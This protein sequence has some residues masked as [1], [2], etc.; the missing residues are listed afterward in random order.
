MLDDPTAATPHFTPD[1]AGAYQVA[2]VVRDS[3]GLSSTKAVLNLNVAPCGTSN[4][5]WNGAPELTPALIEPGGATLTASL[6]GGAWTGAFVGTI[7][8]VNAGFVDPPGCG[9]AAVQPFTYQWALV[10]RPAG[11]AAHLDSSTLAIPSFVPDLPGDYQVAARVGDAMGAI[12]PTRFTTLHVPSCGSTLPVVGITPPG[13]TTLST[14]QALHL[15]VAGGT[16]TD[17]DNLLAICPAR[18]APGPN[19][20]YAWSVSPSGAT[21]ASATGAATDFT[22]GSP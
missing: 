7:V 18:L 10:S 11:S 17:A 1:V 4:L 12:L 9:T 19:F 13:S 6:A 20:A 2:L 22:G 15:T 21:L 14:F 3:H 8:A 5:A 16:A